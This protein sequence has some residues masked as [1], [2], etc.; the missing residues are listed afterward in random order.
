MS[1]SQTPDHSSLFL[2]LSG[3]VQSPRWQDF[4]GRKRGTHPHGEKQGYGDK[5]QLFCALEC[6]LLLQKE[7]RKQKFGPEQTTALLLLPGDAEINRQQ[8]EEKQELPL[9]KVSF[10]RYLLASDGRRTVTLQGDTGPTHSRQAIE[11][12]VTRHRATMHRGQPTV[13]KALSLKCTTAPKS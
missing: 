12:N 2:N 7:R 3:D 11:A 10:P 5:G 4:T 8:F 6:Q 1:D 13:P 9:V